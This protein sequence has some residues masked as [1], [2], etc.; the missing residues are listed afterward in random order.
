MVKRFEI[1]KHTIN[2]IAPGLTADSVL[3]YGTTVFEDLGSCLQKLL[4][5]L[6]FDPLRGPVIKREMA[7]SSLRLL[8]RGSVGVFFSVWLVQT[9]SPLLAG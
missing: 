1:W 7:D 2:S 4:F 3:G 6:D 5:D 8:A 9:W